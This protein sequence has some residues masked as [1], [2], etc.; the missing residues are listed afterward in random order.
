MHKRGR[1]QKIE[2]TCA[3]IV[4]GR[5]SEFHSVNRRATYNETKESA[6]K[7]RTALSGMAGGAIGMATMIFKRRGRPAYS[8][9]V[10]G[11]NGGDGCGRRGRFNQPNPEK[12]CDY[13]KSDAQAPDELFLKP[14][15]KG[16]AGLLIHRSVQR[17]GIRDAAVNARWIPD[18]ERSLLRSQPLPDAHSRSADVASDDRRRCRRDSGRV[19]V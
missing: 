8:E 1:R 17:S 12:H 15:C 2:K 3:P 19:D 5:R 10:V 6:M 14:D 11:R 4:T 18:S 16:N 9:I 7:T 13:G